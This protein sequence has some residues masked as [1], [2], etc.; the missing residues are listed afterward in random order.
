NQSGLEAFHAQIGPPVTAERR[1]L[2]L[3]GTHVAHIPELQH[4]VVYDRMA[5]A[6]RVASA[7]GTFDRTVFV[8]QGS[9]VARTSGIPLRHFCLFCLDRSSDPFPRLPP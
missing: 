7:V 6:R 4:V 9:P 8:H 5:V 1:D 3:R 2:P